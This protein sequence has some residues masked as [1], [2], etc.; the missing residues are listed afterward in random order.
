[1]VNMLHLELLIHARTVGD[2]MSSLEISREQCKNAAEEILRHALQ[3]PYLMHEILSFSATHL[4]T[5]RPS[6][7][8]FLRNQAT[9]L[10]TSALSL[11]NASMQNTSRND[12]S[13]D[14][15]S[16]FVFSSLLGSHMLHDTI[17]Y[18]DGD[19]NAFIDDFV[20][21]LHVTKGVTIHIKGSWEDLHETALKPFL[22]AGEKALHGGEVEFAPELENLEMLLKSADLGPTS[23]KAYENALRFLKA[24]Y[25]AD[26]QV[27]GSDFLLD[28][29][30]VLYG[31][32][33]GVWAWPI[34]VSSEYTELILQR[35]PEALAILA[36]YA[37]LLHRYRN[38]WMIGDG[39]RYMI[40]AITKYLGPYW[41]P[42]LAAPNEELKASLAP[43]WRSPQANAYY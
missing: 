42:W 8:S 27:A 24:A 16:R 14:Y 28:G 15:V 9:E 2:T 26:R 3:T 1:M 21:F 39:G 37:I 4:S 32:R 25:F 33:T 40:E 13:S 36:H 38:S 22:V 7:R 31:A 41:E 23:A 17:L 18:R 11:F 35:R 43:G 10:Q 6:Q 20:R 19:F 5:L 29:N 30:S 12:P 34:L